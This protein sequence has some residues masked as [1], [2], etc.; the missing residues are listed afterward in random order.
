LCAIEQFSSALDHI[1]VTVCHGIK[2]ARVN[3]AA[4]RSKFAQ[5]IE[6]EKMNEKQ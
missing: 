5:E 1:E 2:A 6:N 4:H 3:C